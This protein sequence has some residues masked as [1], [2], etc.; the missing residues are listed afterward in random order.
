MDVQVRHEDDVTVQMEESF[1]PNAD[2]LPIK[3]QSHIVIQ[4]HCQVYEDEQDDLMRLTLSLLQPTNVG[5]E[6]ASPPPGLQLQLVAP[7]PGLGHPGVFDETEEDVM[8]DGSN[9]DDGP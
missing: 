8:D 5:A 3:V 9:E 7:S 2:K 4:K 6:A 1:G